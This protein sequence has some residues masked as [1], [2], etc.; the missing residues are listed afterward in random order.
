MKKQQSKPVLAFI[1]AVIF[2]GCSPSPPDSILVQTADLVLR[3]GRIV[4]LD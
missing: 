2:P 3:G 1:V 4:T